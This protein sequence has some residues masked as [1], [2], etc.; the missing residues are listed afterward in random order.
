MKRPQ[1]TPRRRAGGVPRRNKALARWGTLTA[2]FSLLASVLVLPAGAAAC[3]GV[4]KH[5]NWESISVRGFSAGGAGLVD[6]AVADTSPDLLLATNGT[7][8]VRS[9][10]GG[11]SWRETF[12]AAAT[13]PGVA[14]GAVEIKSIAMSETATSPVL[15]LAEERVGGTIRPRV[16]RSTN[17]GASFSTS[18]GGLLPAGR[19]QEL[20]VAPSSP[21]V[22]YLSVTHGD[23]LLDQFY[24]TE[25]GGQNWSLR[26]DLAE[27]AKQQNLSGFEV[28]T[29][30]GNELWATGP[31][32]A[33]HSV[34]GA[35]TFT[36]V[37][38][39]A[40]STTG[41]VDVNAAA[42]GASRI[43]YFRPAGPDMFVSTNGGENW[44][45]LGTPA[46]VDS[47]AHGRES[48][49][50]LVS[51]GGSKVYLYLPIANA[52]VDLNAVPG[53]H[54]VSVTR[55]EEGGYYARTNSTIEHYIGKPP[56]VPPDLGGPG[57]TVLVPSIDDLPEIVPEPAR[58]TGPK[59]GLVLKPGTTRTLNYTLQLA[60]GQRPLD[61]FFLVDTTGSMK[62]FVDGLKLSLADIVQGLS[63]AGIGARV[64]LGEYRAYPDTL[65][66][67][68]DEPNFV[69][70]KRAELSS[71]TD[72]LRDALQALEYDGGG[73]YDAQLGALHVVA[74]GEAVD[75]DP[76]GPAGEDVPAGEQPHFDLA[77]QQGNDPLRLVL[78]VSNEPFGR[79]NESREDIDQID[80]YGALSPPDIPS[81]TQV[82][83]E[84]EAQGIKQIGLELGAA[85]GTYE[86]L[87]R[88]AAGT[89]A[90]APE[91]GVD[92]DGDGAIDIAYNEA[93][94]CSLGTDVD[95][96]SNM[97]PAIVNMVKA[98]PL[99]ESPALSVPRGEEVVAGVTPD[100]YDGVPLQSGQSLPF[101]VT[102][103][104]TE[105]QAGEK[106]P[107]TLQAT[108]T[109]GVLAELQT[110]VR[111]APLK[112]RDRLAKLTPPPALFAPAVLIPILPPIAPPTAPIPIS[113]ISS[114]TSSQAQ[115]QAQ[116]QA[117]AAAAAQ[118]QEQPQL[119]F[120]HSQAAKA[121]LAKEEQ[122][123]MSAFNRREP[124]M[125]PSLAFVAAAAAMSFAFGMAMRRKSAFSSA[126]R[127]RR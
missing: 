82:I 12:V 69:Y 109:D 55:T 29:G 92:C 88:V 119:A 31:S 56:G 118:K 26:S 51:A 108:G 100:S 60:K 84:L 44:L 83:G 67:R 2:V 113:E 45:S 95:A 20:R 33:Y 75:V 28:D 24:A 126:H 93:L 50:I 16:F 74:T 62:K 6:Y 8:V 54:D 11:C 21:N 121:E 15:L 9:T 77:A 111:C 3:A 68:P 94:V 103:T 112:G 43:A 80:D 38:D 90:L 79:P 101:Q 5:G 106:F 102:Y 71:D 7:S 4:V 41:P 110:S 73:Q 66:P 30:N 14:G 97:A 99:K 125:P 117:Q 127:R 1:T 42:G 107:V 47:A 61:L 81:I 23:D 22:A 40:G 115:T 85:P 39:L 59:E 32:G 98:L 10:D 105:D 46:D 37:D 27:V 123:E 52:W 48:M 76:Q 25:D 104:C 124:E 19:P 35:R 91:Q 13:L 89:D 86:D 18:D 34:D 53:S 72:A 63:D 87:K 120:A 49:D 58:L 122:Y 64:G 78:N 65:V 96:V 114:A 116:A 17:A 70:E 57:R 36:A